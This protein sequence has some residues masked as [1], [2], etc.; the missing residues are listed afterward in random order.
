MI[1]STEAIDEGASMEGV[2]E[3]MSA[4]VRPISMRDRVIS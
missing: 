1:E 3:D 4:R 2:A